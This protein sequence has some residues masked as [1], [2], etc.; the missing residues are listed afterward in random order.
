[1]KV[2]KSS[3]I[4]HPTS[5]GTLTTDAVNMDQASYCDALTIQLSCNSAYTGTVTVQGRYHPDHDWVA[6]GSALTVNSAA[7]RDQI[8]SR[9]YAPEVRLSSTR[10]SG[11][12]AGTVTAWFGR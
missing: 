5:T 8:F 1:M 4:S 6:L 9:D 12:G 3:V 2:K 7:T 10:S 11:A